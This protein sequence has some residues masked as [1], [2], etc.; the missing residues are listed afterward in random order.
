MFL[1]VFTLIETICPKVCSKSR[2]KG[3]K[4]HFRLICVALDSRVKTAN[5]CLTTQCALL[6]EG[7]VK[8]AG[9][10]PSSVLGIY[11]PRS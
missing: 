2:P 7:E 8:I 6:T 4:V 1:S 3:A 11:G 10:W 9:Y 5:F